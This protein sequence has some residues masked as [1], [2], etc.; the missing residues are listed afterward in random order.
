MPDSYVSRVP[1]VNESMN[2]FLLSPPQFG[3][4]EAA[5]ASDR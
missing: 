4:G 5:A 1:A 3:G 2:V